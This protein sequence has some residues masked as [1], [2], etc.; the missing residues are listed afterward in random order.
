[1]SKTHLQAL[2]DLLGMYSDN[3]T[4]CEWPKSRL[5]IAR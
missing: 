3:K 4:M 1:M 2:V 5:R